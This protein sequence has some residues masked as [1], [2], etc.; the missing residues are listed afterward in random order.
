MRSKN[1]LIWMVGIAVP[2]QVLFAFVVAATVARVKSGSGVFR[3]IYYLPALAPTGRGDAR[4]SSTSSTR[5]P[6]R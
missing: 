5:R 1:T 4:A 3:T 2:L 6:G